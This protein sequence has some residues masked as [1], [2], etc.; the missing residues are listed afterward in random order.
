LQA[1]KA[2]LAVVIIL[3]INTSPLMD[4]SQPAKATYNYKLNMQLVNHGVEEYPL[5][6]LHVLT[7]FPNTTLQKAY[8]VKA[9]FSTDNLS[10]SEYTLTIDEEG[11]TVLHFV[12]LP[13]GLRPASSL[14][15]SLEY[16]L[17]VMEKKIDINELSK[18]VVSDVPSELKSYFTAK[19][20]IW[21]TDDVKLRELAMNLAKGE[22]RVLPIL[23]SFIEWMELNIRYPLYP[24]ADERHIAWYP[25]QT[26]EE[27]EGDCDDLGNLL[28]TLL[29]IRGIPAYL[30]IGV[31]YYKGSTSI[32]LF[33]GSYVRD[34]INAAWHGWVMVYVP[35]VGWVPVDLTYFSGLRVTPTNGGRFQYIRSENLTDHIIGAAAASSRALLY[36]NVTKKDYMTENLRLKEDLK[37]YNLTLIIREELREVIELKPVSVG[38]KPTLT[39]LVIATLL[40]TITLIATYAYL[41]RRARR[42]SWTYIPVK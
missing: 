39:G 41:R 27:K 17:K 9:Y 22:T 25:N 6:N 24:E 10:S 2:F 42:I 31:I 21:D 13:K 33:N 1:F 36:V 14:N 18:G 38:F 8:L 15:L 5:D 35:P 32:R 29:R 16:T 3:L 40:L 30:Q 12:K 23:L 20:G 28:I 7:I 4:D 11:N 26:Y 37:R 34:S 19:T